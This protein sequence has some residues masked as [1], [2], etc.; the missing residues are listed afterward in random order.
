[1]HYPFLKHVF[2]VKSGN[3]F[4]TMFSGPRSFILIANEMKTGLTLPIIVSCR[5]SS[6]MLE[7]ICSNHGQPNVSSTL[8]LVQMVQAFNFQ[9]LYLEIEVLVLGDKKSTFTFAF[10]SV[11]S[12]CL[13]WGQCYCQLQY[14]YAADTLPVWASSLKCCVP[15]GNDC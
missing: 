15:G 6:L 2:T 11:L 8:T 10:D 7:P 1:M 13:S 3:S 5:R 12:R 14:P 9:L 4:I